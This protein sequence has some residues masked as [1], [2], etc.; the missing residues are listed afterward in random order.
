MKRASNVPVTPETTACIR[1]MVSATCWRSKGFLALVH[2]QPKE[3][4]IQA[5][6]FLAT[7]AEL[8]VPGAFQ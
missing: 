5:N 3:L 6:R 2:T 1:I 7:W 4:A 8:S